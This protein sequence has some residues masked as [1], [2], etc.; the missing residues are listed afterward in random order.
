MEFENDIFI[1]YTHVDDIPLL[2]NQY[3]WV[4]S[5]HKLL[6]AFTKQYIGKDIRIWRDKELRGSDEFTPE[7]FE[8][9]KK[10]FVLI[11]IQSPPYI[12]SKWCN[13]EVEKFMEIT[14]S[15]NF[16]SIKNQNRIFKVL[17]FYVEREKQLPKNLGS[18]GYKFY[19][20]D[21]E[22]DRFREIRPEFGDKSS[23]YFSQKIADIVIDI[24]ELINEARKIAYSSES[25]VFTNSVENN[26]KPNKNIESEKIESRD[27]KN[28]YLAYTT[29]ELMDVRDKLKRDL[30]Q[31]YIVLPDRPLPYSA[32]ELE[33]IV[34][35]SLERS[36]LSIHLFGS[37][38]GVPPEASTKSIGELQY[39]FAYERQ[40][41]SQ[42]QEFSQIVWMSPKLEIKDERQQRL[43]D[44]LQNTQDCLETGIEE[45]KT[46][47]HKKLKDKIQAL[48]R[49]AEVGPLY[50]YL[51]HDQQ[52]TRT[53]I[54]PIYNYLNDL[55]Y[56]VRKPKF[57]GSE[58]EVR[59]AHED[60]LRECDAFIIF[61]G[62]GDEDWLYLQLRDFKK[63]SEHT[64]GKPILAKAIYIAEPLTVEKEDYR[65]NEARLIKDFDEFSPDLLAPFLKDIEANM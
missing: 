29:P 45:L 49:E 7:I 35:E 58:S 60:K 48:P 20:H 46:I 2:E 22:Q 11:S 62:K 65:T 47:I 36:Q 42:N 52:D 61:Y 37:E 51:I 64:R 16:S 17:K 54:A 24:N 26:K 4:S 15:Q 12:D 10:S 9:L 14:K 43:I 59:Q 53:D 34:R 28:I 18:E 6:E 44:S 5:F 33:L 50:I 31:Q 1:S 23:Q 55:G 57:S 32:H 56:E 30:S 21:S 13:E 38:Y 27:K 41:K 39:K 19:Q 3:G 8:Q 63:A 25:I 40:M